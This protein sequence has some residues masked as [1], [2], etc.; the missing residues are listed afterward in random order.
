[1]PVKQ[2][3]LS[4]KKAGSLFDRGLG[5]KVLLYAWGLLGISWFVLMGAY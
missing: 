4:S 5:E 1:M 3:I 2:G